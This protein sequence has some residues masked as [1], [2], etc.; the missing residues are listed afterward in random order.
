MQRIAIHDR[1]N[2]YKGSFNIAIE[3]IKIKN[4]TIKVAFDTKQLELVKN[5]TENLEIGVKRINSDL[6]VLVFDL[7]DYHYTH[8]WN[9]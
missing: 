7:K 1:K 3:E 6:S 4:R 2:N 5:K 8:Y 9:G